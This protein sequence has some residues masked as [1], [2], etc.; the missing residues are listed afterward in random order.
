MKRTLA[1]VEQEL[2]ACDEKLRTQHTDELFD[3]KTRLL[4]ERKELLLEQLKPLRPF[5]LSA[6][7]GKQSMSKTKEWNAKVENLS[8][9]VLLQMHK[10]ALKAVENLG[11]MLQIDIP[12]EEAE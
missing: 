10:D 9:S 7:G 11:K 4:A 12:T 5:V 8:S 2:L 1:D 3:E 6:L